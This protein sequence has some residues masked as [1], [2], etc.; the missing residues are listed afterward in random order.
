MGALRAGSAVREITPQESQFLFGYPH[1]ERYSTG[2]H[3]PLLSSALYLSD[4]KEEVLII[5]NDIIFVSKKSTAIIRK[6]ICDKISISEKNILISATHTHSGPKTMDYISNEADDIVPK[7][8]TQYVQ[9][10]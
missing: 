4:G 6:R 10:M 3:D 9:Y 5:A 7:A 1:V 8:D 2:V